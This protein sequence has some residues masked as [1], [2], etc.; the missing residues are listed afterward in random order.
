MIDLEHL[1]EQVQSDWVTK[2][3]VLFTYVMRPGTLFWIL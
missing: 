3:F 1:I 2:R